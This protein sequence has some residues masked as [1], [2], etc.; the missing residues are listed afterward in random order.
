MGIGIGIRI[1]SGMGIRDEGNGACA[2][3]IETVSAGFSP[4]KA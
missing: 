1:G 4:S 2:L 3:G